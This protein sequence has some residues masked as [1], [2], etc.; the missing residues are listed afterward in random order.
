V[1]RDI[2]RLS[3]QVVVRSVLRALV[4]VAVL[5]TVYY[6][7]PLDRAS[8]GAAAAVLAVGLV[9]LVILVVF[10]VRSI[11]FSPHPVV[12]AVEAF[13]V[14]VSLVLLLFASAYESMSSISAGSFTGR[15]THTDALYF[16]VTVFTTVGF[17]D[18]TAR[19]E[20]ARLVV[21]GQMVVDVVI[22]GFVVKVITYLVK[23]RR[24]N[25]PPADGIGP[26]PPS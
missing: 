17:G 22:I 25:Q 1:N 12:R 19:T 23:A 11:I 10:Q 4:S 14:S 24:G 8:T 15:L 13:A 20:T 3:V 2:A 18:I 21:T 5:V 9:L 16:T 7:L 6:L 26:D